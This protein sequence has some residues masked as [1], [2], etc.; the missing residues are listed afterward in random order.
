[1]LRTPRSLPCRRAGVA[2]LAA[3]AGLALLGATDAGAATATGQVT[4]DVASAT[5]T[6]SAT[7]W[8]GYGATVAYNAAGHAAAGS[9]AVT[10]G[11]AWTG[12]I[13]PAFTVTP[14][15]RYTAT[16][17]AKAATAAHSVGLALRF[18]TSAG[19]VIDAG[20]QIGQGLTDSTTGWTQLAPAV[21]FA[22]TGAAKAEVVVLDFDGPKGDVQLF[23]D[24][25]VRG[26]TGTAAKLVGPLTTKGTAVY[27]ATGTKVSFR[28][29]DVD[30]LQYPA[31]AKVAAKDVNAARSWG[32]NLVRIPLAE[33]PVIPGDCSYDATYLTKVDGLVQAA[34][35]QGMVALL[36]LHT[37]AVKACAAPAQQAMPD[38]NAVTF[39]KTVAARYKSNPLV[40]FDLYNEPH[41]ISDAVWRNGGTVTS[42]GVTYTAP[43]MQQLYAAVRGTGATNLITA[44]GPNWAS[45]FPAAA[46][47][48][49]VTNLVYGVHVYTCMTNTPA[50]GGTCNPGPGGALDPSGIL[51]RFNTAQ[52]Q[53]PLM[54]T[55]F[56]WPDTYDGRYVATV[57]DSVAAR[58]WAG[59]DVFAFD[60]SNTGR[61]NLVKDTSAT[62][63]P[64]P[65]GMAVM[66]RMAAG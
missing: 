3:A 58:G 15:T 26:T 1:M 37:N 6:G 48:T 17:W 27:D 4:T 49:G 8:T 29:I 9:V 30:G 14:G 41:D 57:I 65:A 63:N 66:T 28:G 35:S 25:T 47:L 62:P 22:P 13:S 33:N 24:L 10:A 44:S 59:W 34:T 11:A 53:V 23:D 39:W 50:N 18:R 64:S 60:S 16:G 2:A 61:F 38:G 36:D 56:G 54:V 51:N 12:G 55:E 20:T 21:G 7:G 19:A 46:P 5:F 40:A 45:S 43:G 31:T 32:V 42:G 52:T